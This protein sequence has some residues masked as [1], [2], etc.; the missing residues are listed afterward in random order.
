MNKLNLIAGLLLAVGAATAQAGV[1]VDRADV[2]ATATVLDFES[3][4]GEIFASG[5]FNYGAL[6]MTAD[7]Q[8]TVGQNIA[9]LGENGVWGAGNHFL[10]FDHLGNMTLDISFNGHTTKGFAF[11]YSIYEEDLDG[12]A[13]LTARYFDL[14]N[15][16]LKTTKFIYSPFGA[17]TYDQYQSFGYV[18]DTANIARV[19][20]AGDGVVLDNLTYAQVVPEPES[21]AMLLA[22]LGLLG[23]VARRRNK[24]G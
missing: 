12:S 7:Q 1:I 11:D 5:T 17:D 18:S 16:L 3:Y 13:F 8:F 6:S 20:I 4:D 15:Q 22:G 9:A 23:A 24:Q 2:P 21:Y 19:T 14:N 10:S